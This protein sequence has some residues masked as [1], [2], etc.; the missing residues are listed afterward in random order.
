MRL[1]AEHSAEDD[2]GLRASVNRRRTKR[3]L[4]S[5]SR[6]INEFSNKL[7]EQF[8]QLDAQHQ[9]TDEEVESSLAQ[10]ESFQV[11]INRLEQEMKHNALGEFH[12]AVQYERNVSS[13]NRSPRR[14]GDHFCSE[15]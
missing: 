6:G 1:T 12:D 7:N 4:E 15:R 14:V 5:L 11:L 10:A 9:Q 13:P 8:R 2:S 3:G